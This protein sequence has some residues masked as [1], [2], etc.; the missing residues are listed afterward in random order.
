MS[1][2]TELIGKDR[3]DTETAPPTMRRCAEVPAPA[4]DKLAEALTVCQRSYAA[5]SR[6]MSLSKTALDISALR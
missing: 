4:L 2:G 6:Q 1:Q 3:C 5:A